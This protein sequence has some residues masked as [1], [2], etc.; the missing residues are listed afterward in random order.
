LTDIY[1]DPDT[2]TELKEAAIEALEIKGHF[3]LG[4]IKD[5]ETKKDKKNHQRYENAITK[6]KNF[7]L[8]NSIKIEL[9][10]ELS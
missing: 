8:E 4:K 1:N 2:R 9:E 3:F 6:I 5:D 10:E 7:F